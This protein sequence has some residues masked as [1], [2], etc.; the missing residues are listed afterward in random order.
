MSVFLACRR[1]TLTPGT[2]HSSTW[3]QLME[4]LEHMQNDLPWHKR[5]HYTFCRSSHGTKMCEF[6]FW[7]NFLSLCPVSVWSL[8]APWQRSQQQEHQGN[9]GKDN[10]ICL[11]SHQDNSE[12]K[13]TP[14]SMHPTWISLEG[15]KKLL[16]TN[17]RNYSGLTPKLQTTNNSGNPSFWTSGKKKGKR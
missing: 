7:I 9:I 10:V 12:T 4:L 5:G 2:T 3:R 16:G 8:L 11:N 14:E 15:Q 13:D 1:N 6:V 17:I